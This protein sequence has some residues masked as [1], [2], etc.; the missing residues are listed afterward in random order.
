MGRKLSI[1]GLF[2]LLSVLTRG[3]FLKIEILDIDESAHIVGS[4]Q[5]LQ[6][7]L[8]YTDFVNN[9]PPLLYVYY[10]AA[11]LLFGRGM[12]AVHLFTMLFTV[13]L[14]A[15]AA[16]AFYDHS[17]KGVIAGILFLIYSASF[18]AHDMHASHTEILMILPGTWALV[19][20][21]NEQD[22]QQLLRIAG[23][24]FLLG[25]GM[26]LKQPIGI[27]FLA[28]LIS[29]GKRTLK[30]RMSIFL[31]VSMLSFAAPLFI[32]FLLFFLHGGAEEFLYWTILNNL[33][34]SANPILLREALG[35]AAGSLLPFLIVTSPLLWCS[36]RSLSLE[37]S[38]Y[39]RTLICLLLLLSLG[40]C[41]VGFR[42]YPHY[43]ILLYVP[44]SLGAA[45]YAELLL[46]RPLSRS[47]FLLIAYSLVLWVGF[48]IANAILYFGNSNVYREKDPVFLSVATRLRKDECYKNATM[49][50]WGYAPII[51]YYSEIKPASRFVVL[52]QSRLTTYLSGNL[53]SV[54]GKAAI[55]QLESIKSWDLLMSDLEKNKSTYI[56]DTAPAGI[57]RWNMYPLQDFPRLA[58][59]IQNHYERLYEIDNVVIYRRRGCGTQR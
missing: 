22:S 25:L 43:F 41:V 42:F 12:L 26:L 39:R 7:K 48:T 59:Y 2:I 3:L 24:S 21:R 13:P 57:Y 9:K 15:F 52:P 10:A 36:Y 32:T 45:P 20:V 23:A 46:R 19:L 29:C 55:R 28:I 37:T 58:A 33:G 38:A 1:L 6:G 53:E 47:G 18:L 35:R 11:Q 8:L 44:L 5:L 34:Y 56:V 4:W 51:Y 50:V 30:Q 14:T 16:S 27:W 54:R 31:P 49:F 40:A 17:R